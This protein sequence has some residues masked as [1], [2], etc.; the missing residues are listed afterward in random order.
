MKLKVSICQKYILFLYETVLWWHWHL[1]DSNGDNFRPLIF[2]PL[3]FHEIKNII[4]VYLKKCGKFVL[5][6]YSA[7]TFID[8]RVSIMSSICEESINLFD[9]Y[10]SR[11]LW[12]MKVFTGIVQ[13]FLPRFTIIILTW[14]HL[15]KANICIQDNCQLSEKLISPSFRIDVKIYKENKHFSFHL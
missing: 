4:V 10:V 9:L 6:H 14:N 12:W 11:L 8:I 3:K 1:L 2:G 7:Y 15:I 13:P 5:D